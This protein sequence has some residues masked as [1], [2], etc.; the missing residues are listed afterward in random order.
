MRSVHIA[1]TGASMDFRPQ[2]LQ[3]AGVEDRLSP[4]R[5]LLF[6][7]LICAVFWIAVFLAFM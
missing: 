1:A 5:G 3:P 2:Q 4:A 6:G 7:L